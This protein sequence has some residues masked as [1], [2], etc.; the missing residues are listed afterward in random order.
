MDILPESAPTSSTAGRVQG[1]I[2]KWQALRVNRSADQPK[3]RIPPT[4]G[5]YAQ[6]P[7]GLKQTNPKLRWLHAA[8]FFPPWVTTH[9]GCISP[10][11]ISW[12]CNTRTLC[13]K[14]ASFEA[15]GGEVACRKGFPPLGYNTEQAAYLQVLFP[16][17]TAHTVC[18][19]NGFV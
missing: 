14:S 16:G 1:L 13:P 8:R 3:A 11:C 15:P 17:V 2:L 9:V 6:L 7:Y 10:G 5:E 4:A 18:L 19:K 12:Y